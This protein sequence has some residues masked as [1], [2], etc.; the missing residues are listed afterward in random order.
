VDVIPE[1]RQSYSELNY[2]VTSVR[3][4]LP[5]AVDEIFIAL[6][7]SFLPMTAFLW[8]PSYSLYCI[9]FFRPGKVHLKCF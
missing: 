9:L 8:D 1:H 5:T 4:G 2:A 7:G 3:R 6:F